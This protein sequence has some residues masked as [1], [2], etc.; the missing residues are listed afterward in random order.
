M[1][2]LDS[3]RLDRAH[4]AKLHLARWCLAVFV[5]CMLAAIVGDAAWF[6]GAPSWGVRFVTDSVSVALAAASFSCVGFLVHR[7]R[8]EFVVLITVAVLAVLFLIVDTKTVSEWLANAFAIPMVAVRRGARNGL[9]DIFIGLLGV[10]MLSLYITSSIQSM[11]LAKTHEQLKREKLALQRLVD[12]HER[13]RKSAAYEIH[14]GLVQQV[15]GALMLIE[16]DCHGSSA[17]DPSVD[18]AGQ[19]CCLL[20]KTMSEARHLISVL[21]PPILDEQGLVAGIEYLVE[22]AKQIEPKLSVEFEYAFESDFDESQLDATL[23]T[24]LFR[25]AQEALVNVVRHSQSPHARI[26]LQERRGQVELEIAD[27]GVGFDTRS[28]SRNH[29][30]LEGLRERIRILDGDC[31]IESTPDEG[32]RIEVRLPLVFA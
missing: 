27:D 30:G 10:S 4:A 7:S 24:A 20:Q 16:A 5:L 32:T 29:F 23:R 8:R 18:R 1:I 21:R 6:F 25:V 2:R 17:A 14:D 19:A 9:S 13:D 12:A 26:R 11:E 28:I 3:K 22:E 31:T 15:A